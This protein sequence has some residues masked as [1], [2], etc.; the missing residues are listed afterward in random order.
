MAGKGDDQDGR[1][2]RDT[3]SLQTSKGK[4]C[5]E[6]NSMFSDDATHWTDPSLYCLASCSVS[7]VVASPGQAGAV[8]GKGGGKAQRGN[9]SLNSRAR[10]RKRRAPAR[11]ASTKAR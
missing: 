4:D 5:S 8:K 9:I 2:Y 10:S 7:A 11:K 6:K 1:F 3:C